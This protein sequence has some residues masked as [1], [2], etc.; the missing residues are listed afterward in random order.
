MNTMKNMPA[1]TADNAVMK[2]TLA[3][4]GTANYNFRIGDEVRLGHDHGRYVIVDENNRIAP[5]DLISNISRMEADV[6]ADVKAV[7]RI[8]SVEGNLLKAEMVNP[9][10]YVYHAGKEWAC[11][12]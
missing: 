11:L 8:I 6:L 7:F 9:Y 12:N 1:E 4:E 2:V 5:A 3:A 10:N